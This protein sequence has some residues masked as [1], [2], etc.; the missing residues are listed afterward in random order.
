MKGERKTRK[1][2]GIKR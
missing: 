1:K 2:E